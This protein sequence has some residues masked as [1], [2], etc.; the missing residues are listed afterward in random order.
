MAPSIRFSVSLLVYYPEMVSI[1]W[2]IPFL[3]EDGL[4]TQW[5]RYGTY[6]FVPAEDDIIAMLDTL[7]KGNETWKERTLSYPNSIRPLDVHSL[8]LSPVLALNCL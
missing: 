1:N 2:K 5:D 7:R 6:C 8:L 3:V 4:H